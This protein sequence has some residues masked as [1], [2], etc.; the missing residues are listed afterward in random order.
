MCT[1]NIACKYKIPRGLLVRNIAERWRHQRS[2]SGH[3]GGGK[4]AHAFSSNVVLVS[5]ISRL[6]MLF[7]I[8][9]EGRLFDVQ[10]IF[11][12]F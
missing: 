7:G 6:S 1:N 10:N 4:N 8:C 2:E 5:D 11:E 3:L 12:K 9:M